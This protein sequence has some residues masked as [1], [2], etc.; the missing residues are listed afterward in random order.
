MKGENPRQL[1]PVIEELPLKPLTVPLP[2]GKYRLIST[3]TR[4]EMIARTEY[5]RAQC[6]GK[7][8]AYANYGVEKVDVLTCGDELVCDKCKYYENHNPWKIEDVGGLLPAHPNCRCTYKAHILDDE[9]TEKPKDGRDSVIDE[10]SLNMAKSPS[11]DGGNTKRNLDEQKVFS[12]LREGLPEDI[13]DESVKYLAR[14]IVKNGNLD[15]ET[16]GIFDYKTG[17]ELTKEL[18]G[19]YQKIKIPLEGIAFKPEG[20][21]YKD[22]NKLKNDEGEV[23][24]S[25]LTENLA[26]MHIHVNGVTPPSPDDFE[27]ALYRTHEKYTIILSNNEVWVIESYG[28]YQRDIIMDLGNELYEKYYKHNNTVQ[29]NYPDD[30]KDNRPERVKN[31]NKL[32]GDD[33]IAI[34]LRFFVFIFLFFLF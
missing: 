10:N 33:V 30:G 13:S 29:E 28:F 12:K 24:F 11:I 31:F 23:R 25:D 6:T 34:K 22:F 4:A 15:R 8:Q 16:G 2:N 19:K 9:I 27:L 32:Y 20:M 21:S 26:S 1:I 3:R 18:K 7:L 14:K 17:F 5:A